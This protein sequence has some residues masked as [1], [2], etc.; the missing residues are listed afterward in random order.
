MRSGE[1]DVLRMALLN[2]G[3]IP[4]PCGPDGKSLIGVWGLDSAP[5]E[6]AIR[7]WA[8]SYPDSDVGI[9]DPQTQQVAV[10][11]EVPL[12]PVQAEARRVEEEAA[13]AEA[14]AAAARERELQRERQRK[15]IQRRAAGKPTR[16]EWLRTHSSKPWE[17]AN[18][19]RTTWYRAKRRGG[20]GGVG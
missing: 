11:C 3:H 15:E 5:S 1:A 16:E 14:S 8:T 2:A 6:G 18:M 17:A 4:V 13:R 10:V 12:T 20:I 9:Y 7:T 19:S